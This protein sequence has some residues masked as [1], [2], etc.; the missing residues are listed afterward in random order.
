MSHPLRDQ[1]SRF[2]HSEKMARSPYLVWVLGVFCG[3]LQYI[4]ALETGVRCGS[5]GNLVAK[6]EV[7]S[8]DWPQAEVVWFTVFPASLRQLRSA[9]QKTVGQSC[10]LQKR[11]TSC[12]FLFSCSA[13]DGTQGSGCARQVSYQH[14][15]LP[16]PHWGMLGRCFTSEL[17]LSPEISS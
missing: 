3:S 6:H 7:G 13:R 14:S 5:S 11:K 12:L 8:W 2:S 15:M 9:L 1:P 17:D 4:L 16:S 10:L